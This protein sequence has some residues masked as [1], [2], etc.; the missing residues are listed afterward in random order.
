MLKAADH[1]YQVLDKPIKR[2]NQLWLADFYFHQYKEAHSTLFLDRAIATLEKSMHFNRDKMEME[3]QSIK[4]ADLY[5]CKKD[6]AKRIATLAALTAEYAR[7][8]DAAWQYQRLAQ[9]N[10]A[11]AYKEERLYD[12]ALSAYSHLITS[13]ACNILFF[14]RGG[15]RQGTARIFFV[16]QRSRGTEAANDLRYS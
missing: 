1:L 13:L 9:F 16:G 3:G 4:L 15:T 7:D 11:T 12:K 2:E 14:R 8:P 6:N 5:G 10:L